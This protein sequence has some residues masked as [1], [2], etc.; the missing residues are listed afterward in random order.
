MNDYEDYDGLGLAA[1]VKQRQV[2]AREL[3]DAAIARYERRNP[4]VNAVV[5][6]MLEQARAATA[7]SVPA[8]PFEGVPFLLKDL[9]L[10]VPGV[11]TTQGSALYAEHVPARESEL[12]ARYRRAGLVVFGKSATPEFGLTCTTESRLFGATRNPW[13]PAHT[14]GGSS[15]GASAAVAAGMVALANASDGGGSI[16]VPASCCGLFGLKPT[17]GRTP[18]G[19]DAGEGWSGMSCLHA[20][21]RSVRDSAALLDAT[22]GPDLGAPYAAQ[23]PQ[24]PWLDEVGAPPGRLR[25]ALQTETWNDAVTHPDCAAAAQDAARLCESLGHEV[26]RA[27]FVPSNGEEMRNAALTVVAA[28]VLWMVDDGARK[29]GRAARPDDVEPGT[30]ALVRMASELRAVDYAGALKVLHRTGREL[31]QFLAQ[32]D[33]LLT[34]T[35]ATPPPRIGVLSLSNPDA[36]EQRRVLMEAIGYTQLANIAGTPAMSV[37]LWW[38]TAGLPIGVQF[39]GRHHDEATLFRLAAQLEQARPWLARRAPAA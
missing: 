34:P 13:N 18:F 21:T 11:R 3:L 10:N 2:S 29:L 1:L 39:I 23:P 27:R 26:E 15:G 36:T 17:R 14:S 6:P 25:I 30:W 16:R 38:N 5:V 33:A 20:V 31:A 24:R 32:Y 28:N 7:G 8:G 4:G 35:M 9:G 19:P 22:A 37:P 12:V